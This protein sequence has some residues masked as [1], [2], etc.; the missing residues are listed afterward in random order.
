MVSTNFEYFRGVVFV[1]SFFLFLFFLF[2]ICHWGSFFSFFVEHWMLEESKKIQII[3]KQK[4]GDSLFSCPSF[5]FFL[6]RKTLTNEEQQPPKRNRAD[7]G[8]GER[9]G[10]GGAGGGGGVFGVAKTIAQ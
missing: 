10:G 3:R 6:P 9:T 8:G 7:G 1:C 2:V 5:F 4:R